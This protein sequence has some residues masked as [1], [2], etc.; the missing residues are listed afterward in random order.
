MYHGT[1]DRIVPSGGSIEFFY[2]LLVE[3]KELHLLDGGYH[4]PHNDLD[5]DKVF[6][7]IDNWLVKHI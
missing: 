7:L 3:D 1:E 4:E 6:S 2:S 5:K